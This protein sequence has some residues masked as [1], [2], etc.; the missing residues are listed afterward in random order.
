MIEIERKFLVKKSAIDAQFVLN[1]HRIIRMK[2]GY[3]SNNEKGS[4]RVRIETE[5][6]ESVAWLNSKL[7]T[8]D[9][10]TSHEEKCSIPVDY[11][12]YVLKHFCINN[13]EKTRL[14]V[15]F[16]DRNWE[17]DIFRKPDP[18]LILAEIELNSLDEKITLPDWVGDEVTGNAKYYNAN[19]VELPVVTA[20]SEKK[21]GQNDIWKLATMFV[22]L[23][24]HRQIK[25]GRAMDYDFLDGGHTT[26][27]KTK[28]FFSW[29]KEQN[30]YSKLDSILTPEYNDWK[31]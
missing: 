26:E 1:A 15:I 3:I 21:Y 20:T 30:L 8:D 13:I 31:Q 14:H 10:S 25:V 23:P 22:Q 28:S 18:S 24:Y 6:G 9:P 12:E 29:V 7:K 27:E 4:V 11:A 5:N 19:M 2:Q 16:D 17:I